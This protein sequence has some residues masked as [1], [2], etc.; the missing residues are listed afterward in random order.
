MEARKQPDYEILEFEGYTYHRQKK[1]RETPRGAL[2]FP[3]EGGRKAR[4][5]A[6]F[7]QI[8][9][10]YRLK[11]GVKRLFGDES[12]FAEEKL[13]GYNARIFQQAGRLMAATRGG[14]ICPFTTEW[15][16]IWGEDKNLNRFFRDFPNYVL[17]GEVI[18]DNPYNWQRDPN[19]SPGA[20]F[21]VFEITAPDGRFLAPAER[22][23]I[24]AE[25]G[26]PTVPRM[27]EHSAAD[28]ETLYELMRKL[29]DRG[30]EGVVLKDR[31]G[32]R[33]LKF[34]TPTTDLQD[35]KDAM[36]IGFDL[37]SGFFFNRYL[38]ASIF[39][40]ELGLD[41][42][43][44]APRIGWS[45]LDGCPDPQDFT[46]ASETYT[47]FVKSEKTWDALCR[48]LKSRVRIVCDSRKPVRIIGRELLRIDFR[49]IYQ[50]SSQ[51]FK[52]ILKGHLHTD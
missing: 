9:R 26:L 46:E 5:V 20:H 48:Q 12:F 28:I 25:Y 35:I 14:F 45:F 32:P 41:P 15:A 43:E 6:G 33:R 50:K 2:G 30:R 3:A 37:S 8:Q 52:R 23:R 16:G 11:E 47:V 49:R 36:C 39:V 31:Q 13:D 17:C 24:V 38:R 22:Y 42:E 44:Y 1:D 10:V 51:R 21:F 29:N 27:G 19:L 7:P 34:V 40:Q 18:G 4:T